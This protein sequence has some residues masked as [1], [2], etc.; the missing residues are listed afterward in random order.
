MISLR[1]VPNST[2]APRRHPDC[3]QLP[4]HISERIAH[5]F[6]RMAASP[7]RRPSGRLHDLSDPA[8][9]L[10]HHPGGSAARSCLRR[11]LPASAGFAAADFATDAT[12]AAAGEGGTSRS[13]DTLSP[14][15][16]SAGRQPPHFSSASCPAHACPAATSTAR[17]AAH[18]GTLATHAAP[19][20]TEHSASAPASAAVATPASPSRPA[21]TRAAPP[22]G[23]RPQHPRRR[24]ALTVLPL[25]LIH[26]REA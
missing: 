22:P 26:G 2:L 25:T 21:R 9:P 23:R 5:G 16:A 20:E 18:A 11:Q 10:P 3:T 13:V 8:E 12:P 1:R 15:A 6:L 17:S 4:Q 14:V 19:A 24:R 7:P